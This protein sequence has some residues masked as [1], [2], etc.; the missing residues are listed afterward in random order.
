MSQAAWRLHVY[1]SLAS[2]SDLCRT[3]AAEGEPDGLA[4]LARRQTAGRGSRGREWS[5]DPGN[6]ALSVLIRPSDR[7][8]DAGLWALLAGVAVAQSLDRDDV[9]LKWPNDLLLGGAKCGGILVETAVGASGGLDWLVIGMG[10]NLTRVPD[11]EGRRLAA[12]GARTTPE[13]LAERVLERLAHWR[14]LRLLDGWAPIRTA[15]LARAVPLGGLM[16]WRQGDHEIAGAFAGLG[17]DGSLLLATGGRVHAFSSGEI[18]LDQS[19][20]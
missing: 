19:A 7:P 6:F 11:I 15:W 17:E 9:V 10:V 13:A 20:C 2:T 1:E 14:R 3:L 5:S 8:R 16:T 18:W 12:I 4:V